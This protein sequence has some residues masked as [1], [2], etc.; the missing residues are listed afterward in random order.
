ML[1]LSLIRQK[2]SRTATL[3]IAGSAR[4]APVADGETLLGAAMREEIPFP[5]LCNVGEC[6]ACKCRLTRGH[7]RLAKDISHLVSPEEL[8]SGFVLACQSVAESE[9]VEIELPRVGRGDAAPVHAEATITRMTPLAP[10]ILA[11]ELGLCAEVRY[12]AGQHLELSVPSVPALRAPRCYSYAEA[13]SRA[14]RLRALFHVR[15]VPGGAFTDWL[16]TADRTGTRLRVSGP[17]GHL[18]Y[19]AS[20]RPLLCV[21]GGTGLAPI[22]AILEQAISE[23]PAR[24]VTLVVG[25]RTRED[26]YALDAIAAIGERWR[27]GFDFV[28]VLSEEPGDSAW[29]GRRGLVTAY[30]RERAADL[31]GAAAYLCGPPRMID[32]ALDLLRDR[33]PREHLHLDRFLDRGSA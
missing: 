28:P 22:K 6:G 27:G 25:A 19:H 23:G 17:H 15:H 3:H 7:V 14:S 30:L 29:S 24:D 32:A 18:R 21:A 33:I 10:S 26:L 5:H 4:T 16:F 1:G 20:A 13:P 31:D 12:R 9:D 8:A 11:V 2:R